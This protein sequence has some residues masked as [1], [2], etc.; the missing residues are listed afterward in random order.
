MDC[1]Q[2]CSYLHGILHSYRVFIDYKNWFLACLPIFLLGSSAYKCL[3]AWSFLL[4]PA[5]LELVTYV[6]SGREI[7]MG[8]LPSAKAS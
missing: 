1:F 2:A 8:P 6:P 5:A 3:R 7:P 4:D